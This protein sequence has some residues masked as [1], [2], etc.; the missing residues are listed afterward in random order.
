M[1]SYGN[2]L[3][4]LSC[5][6][7]EV[8]IM[9]LPFLTLLIVGDLKTLIFPFSLILRHDR[10]S[11]ETF[12]DASTHWHLHNPFTCTMELKLSFDHFW[13]EKILWTSLESVLTMT[14]SKYFFVVI[15]EFKPCISPYLI[16]FPK[17][18]VSGL[19]QVNFQCCLL[20]SL[21]PF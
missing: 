5:L 4:A 20:S 21:Q 18:W 7:Y 11:L 14:S 12:Q 8:L 15:M 10:L 3:K 19:L 9:F 17:P 2:T 16:I 6:H 1:I 13:H